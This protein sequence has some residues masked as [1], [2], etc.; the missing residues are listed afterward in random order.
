MTTVERMKS[1]KEL[2]DFCR[3][4]G[5]THLAIFGS[6]LNH[7][8]NHNDIDLIIELSGKRSLFRMIRLSNMLS[9]ILKSN[10]DL[11]TEDSLSK[12]IKDKV[13]KEM[14]TVYAG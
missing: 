6:A 4:N 8:D 3:N 9:K 11:V 10:I 1:S 5:I 13:K 2:H 12:Y 7:D 14:V